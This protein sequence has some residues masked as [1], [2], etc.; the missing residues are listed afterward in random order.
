MAHK[1]LSAFDIPDV[2]GALDAPSGCSAAPDEWAL[3]CLKLSSVC[4]A[5]LAIMLDQQAAEQKLNRHAR[6]LATL[7]LIARL[8]VRVKHPR[9]EHNVIEASKYSRLDSLLLGP[10]KLTQT[11]S[12]SSGTLQTNA[13]HRVYRNL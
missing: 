12:S 5:L 13:G 8:R 9:N 11:A 10:L 3:A 2:M 1:G 7:R 4:A 6:W